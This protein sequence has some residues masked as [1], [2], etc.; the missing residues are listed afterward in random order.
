MP[1]TMHVLFWFPVVL[2]SLFF[3]YV[4]YNELKFWLITLL[5]VLLAAWYFLGV[6]FFD[7][8]FLK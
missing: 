3:L 1:L 8:W 2:F 7:H 5:F 4:V 6:S